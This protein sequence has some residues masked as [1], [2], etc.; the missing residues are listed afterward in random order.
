LIKQINK[1]MK[2]MCSYCGKVLQDEELENPMTDGDNEIMCD[3]CYEEAYMRYCDVCES[4][5]NIPDNEV[6]TY[7]FVGKQESKDVDLAPGFYQ[8]LRFPIAY[9]SIIG[10][11]QIIKENVKLLRECDIDSILTQIYPH[12]DYALGVDYCC[13]E[14]AEKYSMITSLDELD[15]R[16]REIIIKGE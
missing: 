6:D 11:S 2:E 1:N 8:A 14:C 12:C 3:A 5:Y 15:E 10:Y 7:F 13:K 16:E 9:G 4:H